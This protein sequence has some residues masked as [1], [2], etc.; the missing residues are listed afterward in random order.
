VFGFADE[1]AGDEQSKSFKD[2]DAHQR[3][4]VFNQLDND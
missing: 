3:A 1:Q 4:K 2:L